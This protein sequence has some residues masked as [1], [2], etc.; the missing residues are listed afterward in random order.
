MVLDNCALISCMS[1]QF[2]HLKV[3]GACPTH[4]AASM[5]IVPPLELM[6][7]I[8]ACTS[9]NARARSCRVASRAAPRPISGGAPDISAAIGSTRMGSAVGAN[10][11]RNA[12]LSSLALTRAP[13]HRFLR[14]AQDRLRRA[15]MPHGVVSDSNTHTREHRPGLLLSPTPL[16]RSAAPILHPRWRSPILPA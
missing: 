9:S 7:R 16:L 8:G 13:P 12:R 5:S 6:H 10:R 1:S 4:S 3:A 2:S 14:Q 15:A 11:D